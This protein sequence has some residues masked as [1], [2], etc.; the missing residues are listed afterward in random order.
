MA[1]VKVRIAVAVT[2]EGEWN[3]CGWSGAESD[4]DK[5][6]ICVD[7]LASGE[8]RYWLEAE[9]EVPSVD[10]VQASVSAV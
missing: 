3:A 8:K 1:T 5:M 9:L 6:S 10:V 4:D 7:S 2:P